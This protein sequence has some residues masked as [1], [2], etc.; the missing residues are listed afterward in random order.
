[1]IAEPNEAGKST[2]VAKYLEGRVRIVNPDVIARELTSEAPSRA[3][4]NLQAG[5]EVIRQQQD[6]LRQGIDFAVEATL[7][8]NRELHL[9]QQVVKDAAFKVNFVFVGIDRPGTS[10]G[11][12][13]VRVRKGGHHVPAED[14]ERRFSRSMANLPRALELADRAYVLDNSG[15]RYRLLLSMEQ[16]QVK[17]ITRNLPTWAQQTLPPEYQRQQGLNR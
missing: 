2:L 17:R 15:P 12:I 10:V 6:C 8:G 13:A 11:R 3:G 4:V 1:M 9:L 7:S 5:R 16:G 14:I